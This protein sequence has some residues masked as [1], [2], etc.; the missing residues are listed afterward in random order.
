MNEFAY[1]M[2]PKKHESL[3]K[4][5]QKVLENN[6]DKLGLGNNIRKKKLKGSSMPFVIS[7]D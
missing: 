2:V 4:A 6:Q 5:E 7:I 3:L 1:H